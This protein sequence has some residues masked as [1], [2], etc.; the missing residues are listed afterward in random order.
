MKS[1]ELVGYTYQADMYCP[2]DV[3]DIMAQRLDQRGIVTVGQQ[4]WETVEEYLDRIA[5]FFDV[6][7]RYD[8]YTFDSDT[9]P[10]VVF[11][12]QAQG[13]DAVCCECGEGL[14]E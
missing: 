8:E 1:Y 13:D 9:F 7:D 5:P 12:D 4:N 14:V 2:K 11:S 3:A 10:K 6:K